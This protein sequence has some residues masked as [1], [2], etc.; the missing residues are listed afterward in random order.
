MKTI[1]PDGRVFETSPFLD[2]IFKDEEP[3]YKYF[4]IT[5]DREV[6]SS[7][8]HEWGVWDKK[9]KEVVMKRMEDITIENDEL[10]LQ[11]WE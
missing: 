4:F 8:R 7:A 6:K 9:T 11:G 3:V 1:L 2:I 5:K 10:L